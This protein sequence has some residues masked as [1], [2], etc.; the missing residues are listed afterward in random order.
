[1]EPEARA[2]PGLGPPSLVRLSLEAAAAHDFWTV[3]RRTVER[4][5]PDLANP[6][7][8]ALLRRGAFDGAPHLLDRFAACATRVEVDA[9]GC[10]LTVSPAQLI[11]WLS[12]F[13]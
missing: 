5:P 6:L 8:A 7:L 1:M 2:Q 9:R 13:R 3:Q 11:A 10:E 4:L 12:S